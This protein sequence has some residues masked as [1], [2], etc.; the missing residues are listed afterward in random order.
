LIDDIKLVPKIIFDLIVCDVFFKKR[1][2]LWGSSNPLS[3]VIKA[4]L[5]NL[6]NDQ[7]AKVLYWQI[8]GLGN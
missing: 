7:A 8:I 5:L 4:M 1:N 3:K 6:T 2:Q